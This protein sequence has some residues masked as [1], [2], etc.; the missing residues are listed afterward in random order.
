MI[1]LPVFLSVLG[2]LVLSMPAL[3]IPTEGAVRLDVADGPA[4]GAPGLGLA[5]YKVTIPRNTTLPWHYH[6]GSQ[7]AWIVRGR[8]HYSVV[9]GTAYETI[10]RAGK[11]PRRV[12]IPAG[13][14]AVIEAGHGLYEPKGMQHYATTP[15]GQVITVVTVL[16]PPKM[17]GT[18]ALGD[19]ADSPFPLAP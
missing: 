5:M 6:P 16:K 11:S 4:S 3:G 12:A 10:P 17:L 13:T 18:I 2:G 9:K 15:E 7:V 14:R 19:P 8:L 1:K